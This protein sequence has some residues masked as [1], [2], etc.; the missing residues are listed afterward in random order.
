M[1][2]CHKRI[3]LVDDDRTSGRMVCGVLRSVGGYEVLLEPQPDRAVAQAREFHPDLVVLDVEESRTDSATVACQLKSDT[4][5]SRI[6]I[7][8]L[9]SLGGVFA[10]AWTQRRRRFSQIKP[11]DILRRVAAALA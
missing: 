5:L 10:R 6:P 9:S 7:L 1:K 8:F 3:L 2:P 11:E 4:G